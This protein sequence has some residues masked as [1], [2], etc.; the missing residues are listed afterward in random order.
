MNKSRFLVIFSF[1]AKSSTLARMDGWD[2]VGICFGTFL[3][4]Y[5]FNWTGYYGVYGL[6]F[7]LLFAGICYLIFVVKFVK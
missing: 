3:S 2:V 5:I 4:P 6:N 7:G 1:L